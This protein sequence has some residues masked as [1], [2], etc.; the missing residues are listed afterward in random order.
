[1]IHEPAQERVKTVFSKIVHKLLFSMM[2]RFECKAGS[3]LAFW[4]KLLVLLAT[5]RK[6]LYRFTYFTWEVKMMAYL[7]IVVTFKSNQCKNPS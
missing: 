5:V 6:T 1:M 3:L 7:I 2:Q 4:Q